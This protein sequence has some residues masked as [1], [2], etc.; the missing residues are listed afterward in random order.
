MRHPLVEVHASNPDCLARLHANL[1]D[2]EPSGI[3]ATIGTMAH[4]AIE[5][6]TIAQE[7]HSGVDPMAVTRSVL[8]TA[9]ARGDRSVTERVVEE[10]IEVMAG[11]FGPK[12]ELKFTLRGNGWK[13][14]SEW[15]WALD[16]D[17]QPIAPCGMCGGTLP[18]E[19]APPCRN[20]AGHFGWESEPAYS[21]TV[22]R[23]EW[24][25][26]KGLII[27]Y[28]WKSTLA[29][30]SSED[31]KSDRQAR[32]YAL[33]I[34]ATFAG[35]KEVTFRKVFL[36]L[37]YPASWTFRAGDPWQD[38]TRE[39]LTLRRTRRL[40]AIERN[41]WPETIGLDCR[42]CPLIYR[43]TAQKQ[44]RARGSMPD[45]TATE[46]ANAYIGLSAQL[47]ELKASL[48]REVQM[49][50]I[51][52]PLDT[53]D[54]EVLGKAPAT[55]WL[56][57]NTYEQT[58]NSL[59]ALGMTSEMKERNFRYVLEHFIASRVRKV[60]GLLVTPKVADEWIKNGDWIVP[61]GAETFEVHVPDEITPT[62]PDVPASEEYI[63]D[64]I[65]RMQR[66]DPERLRK[67]L[68]GLR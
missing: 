5:E 3:A 16:E 42:W 6:Y 49:T 40:E 53:P 54:G 58:M 34:L 27:A 24:H 29:G 55:R 45:A 36:R 38:A 47:T 62:A 33:A 66:E 43:C 28:D 23:L 26:A 63:E 46:R 18:D 2:P 14:V 22:D 67:A 30:D 68:E 37:G 59:E 20:C 61:K 65:K 60:L 56:L 9:V 15:R 11:A 39:V 1:V 10:T 19:L 7:A 8:R 32:Y 64:A 41:E 17:F 4:R 13:T 21:G 50:G 57:K 35:A 12:S 44:A 52:I 31:V 48:V 25:A 51:P